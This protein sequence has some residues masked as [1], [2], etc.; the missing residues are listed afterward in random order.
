MSPFYRQD[1][2]GFIKPEK[3]V[4]IKW[5]MGAGD[6]MKGRKSKIGY[7][8][9]PFEYHADFFNRNYIEDTTL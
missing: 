3:H 1:E 9:S 5:G 6:I 8:L 4:K 2:Y 7:D